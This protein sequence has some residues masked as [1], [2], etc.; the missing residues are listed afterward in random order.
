MSVGPIQPFNHSSFHPSYV[1]AQTDQCPSQNSKEPNADPISMLLANLSKSPSITRLVTLTRTTVPALS[2]SKL[3]V[4]QLLE[5]F[6]KGAEGGYN[7]EARFDYL[8]WFFGDL[9]KVSLTLR[10]SLSIDT[11]LHT[12]KQTGSSIRSLPHDPTLPLHPRPSDDVPPPHHVP[13]PHP[14][15][16]HRLSPQKYRTPTYRYTIPPSTCS[17]RAATDLTTTLLIGSRGLK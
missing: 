12:D 5:L 15:P 4:T 11:V 3:A 16:R 13:L 9:A 2:P 14:S 10:F 17:I 7:P 8:A 1:L 6:N